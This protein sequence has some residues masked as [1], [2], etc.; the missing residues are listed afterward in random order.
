MKQYVNGSNL[1]KYY[2]DT[3]VF[4]NTSFSVHSGQRVALIGPNGTGKTTLLKIIAGIDLADGGEVQIGK[5]TSVGYADQHATFTEND[6][7]YNIMLCEI[8]DNLQI[9]NKIAVLEEAFAQT[10]YGSEAFEKIS[11]Q[12]ELLQQEVQEKGL[13]QQETKIKML[14]TKLG[15]PEVTWHNNVQAL[16]GGQQVRLHLAKILLQEPELLLLDEPTNHLDI[17][18]IIWLNNY[19][20]NYPH[21][22]I[23]IT[24]D[25]KL[26]DTLATNVW[27][28]VNYTLYTYN[29]SYQHF[30]QQLA[31]QSNYLLEQQE[32]IAKEKQ[33]LAT[34]VEKNKARSS[35]AKRAQSAQK[36]LDKIADVQTIKI[37]NSLKPFTLPVTRQS[38][39]FVFKLEHVVVGYDKSL[40]EALDV[41]ILRYERIALVGKNGIGKSTL[42]STLASLIPSLSGSL[43]IGHHV[44]I[45][46]FRQQQI[47]AK[48]NQSVYSTFSDVYPDANREII[49]PILARFGFPQDD[50]QLINSRL[51][52]GEKQRLLLALLYYQ[53]A[54]TLLLDEPTNHLD[55][56]S[57]QALVESFNNFDGTI[58]F[59]S[60][61]REFIEQLATRIFFFHHEKVY[62]FKTYHEFEQFSM[63]LADLTNETE[64]KPK[65]TAALARSEQKKQ[66]TKIRALKR[67]I[68]QLEQEIEVLE[69]Q[70]D[71]CSS[72]LL[73]EENYSDYQKAVLLQNQK[74]TFEQT[75]SVHYETWEV[76][77][78]Q[79]EILVDATK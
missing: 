4:E 3:L 35:T 44:D 48:E 14:L 73:Q 22:I 6:T 20:S 25:E 68:E 26:I 54:N 27:Q 61:D 63:S 64:Q 55:I 2:G 31:E 59:A 67:E 47:F 77:Q 1:T 78:A 8:K 43:Q 75:L 5:D 51:S 28:F 34:F 76:L 7:I 13:Y 40:Y 17:E 30:K 21:A 74:S 52:G 23:L 56:T 29:G 60:H 45:A 41:E 65:S 32:K 18:T 37:K 49:Y 57:K 50:V 36:R 66:Q 72:A 33:K 19:L 11:K 71:D 9:F 42:L 53:K 58:V 16:S 38:G 79:L 46:Y 39:K 15:F 12:Y 69:K 10:E 70:I 62:V 24:H